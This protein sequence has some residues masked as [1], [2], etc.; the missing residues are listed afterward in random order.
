MPE[1]IV[2]LNNVSWAYSRSRKWALQN[3]SLEIAQ[4]EFLA[5]MG[6]NGAGKT[7]LCKLCNGIIPLSQAGNLRGTVTVD[8]IVTAESSVAVLAERVGMA[9]EDPE[10][11][12]FT[13]RVRDEVAFGLENLL[14]PP[15]VIRKKTAWALET[16]GLLRYADVSPAALSGGQKQRL[17]IAAAMVMAEKILVLDEPTAQLDPSGSREV[18]SLVR[19]ICGQRGLT[20]VMST[21]NSEE[22]VEFADRVCVLKNGA[23]AACDTPRN[24]FSD[25][26]LLRESWIRPPQAAELANCMRERGSPLPVFPIYFDEAKAAVREWYNH[27]NHGNG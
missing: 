11:Q 23:M 17:A 2:K 14:L 4:G 1:P 10:T 21:H 26:G 24:I 3:I 13:A 25:D 15:P 19:E 27:E 20:V 5:V 8:G 6:E 12:L 9:L 16:A 18:M 22:A 7:T